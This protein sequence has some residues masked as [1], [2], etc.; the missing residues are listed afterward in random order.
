MDFFSSSPLLH[1]PF[2][3]PMSGL[4]GE[5][6]EAALGSSSAHKDNSVDFDQGFDAKFDTLFASYGFLC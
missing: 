1:I 3:L 4:V 6:S 5:V 2:T